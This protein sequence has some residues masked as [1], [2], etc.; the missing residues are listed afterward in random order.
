VLG[1]VGYMA[2]EQARGE[3]SSPASDRYALACVAFELLTG[4]RPFDRESQAAEAAAH[5]RET[6]PSAR[7]YDP[8]LP[9]ALDAVFARGL[10]KRPAER[11]PTGAA[12]VDD[13]RRA[14]A[15]PVPATAATA[16]T[17]VAAPAQPAASAPSTRYASRPRGVVVLVGVIGLLAAGGALAWALAGVGDGSEGATV[18]LTQTVQGKTVVVTETTPGQTVERTVTTDA[19]TQPQP[20][21]ESGSTLNDRGFR[22][23]QAGDAQ[24]ALPV[25]EAAVAALHGSSSITEAYASYNLAAA[26]FALGRCDGV[27]EL[28]DRSEEIQGR[29]KEI[30]RLRKQVEKRCED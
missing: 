7:Q 15:S 18:V 30:E 1:S 21:G 29:R 4:R 12:L 27:G 2:P 17:V 9:A 24:G 3:P 8:K 28:L 14:L 23:L 22:M 11:H 6:P 10:A 26:R 13:L 20:A 25:L 16:A 5:A 19:G